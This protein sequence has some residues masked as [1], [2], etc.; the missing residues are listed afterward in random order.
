MNTLK[1]TIIAMALAAV[2]TGNAQAADLGPEATASAV[3]GFYLR[4]DIGWSFLEW[5]GDD[6]NAFTGGAGLGYQFT[7]YLRSDLR[8]DYA[9]VYSNGPDMSVT[10]VLGNLYFDIPTGTAFT[11]Y[12][13]AG[14]GYGW[15]PVDGAP[16]KD[17][18]AYALMGGA[19]YELTD[20][21][22][23]DVGYRFRSIAADGADPHEHQVTTGL[24]FK[25]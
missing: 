13:G 24:R 7:D 5:S 6:S 15:A 10:T 19:S 2:A 25:F 20:S 3:P 4:G 14:G 21:L 9:G 12:V 8:V 16:D 22:A 17:G 11:P 1:T 23:L 18:F